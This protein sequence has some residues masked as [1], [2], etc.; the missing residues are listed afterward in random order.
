M[1]N[2]AAGHL[3]DGKPW[4]TGHPQK[5]TQMLDAGYPSRPG[6]DGLGLWGAAGSSQASDPHGNGHT[7]LLS[8]C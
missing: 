2:V 1:G 7:S 4:D 6:P 5:L 3:R 8:V